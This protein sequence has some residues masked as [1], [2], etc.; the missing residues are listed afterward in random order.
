MDELK[1]SLESSANSFVP[2]GNHRL[3]FS[4]AS[5]PR[6]SS[7]P[8]NSNDGASQNNP[9]KN[10]ALVFR[11]IN[12]SVAS[13]KWR[14]SSFLSPLLPPFFDSRSRNRNNLRP[15]LHED[16]RVIIFIQRLRRQQ[17]VSNAH[18]F[19]APVPFHHRKPA[20]VYA[21]LS[22]S[23]VPKLSAAQ[24]QNSLPETERRKCWYTSSTKRRFAR[25]WSSNRRSNFSIREIFKE[26]SLR[27]WLL[28]RTIS[29]VKDSVFRKYILS[30]EHNDISL[31]SYASSLFHLFCNDSIRVQEGN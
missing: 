7:L 26:P 21:S 14:I 3:F 19:R 28:F 24:F 22:L 20:A 25:S 31:E 4:L 11:L 10:R 5:L 6:L 8:S 18:S 12:P 15:R 1:N 17:G 29:H 13:R 16:G 27:N 23:F 9:H 2:R 30:N